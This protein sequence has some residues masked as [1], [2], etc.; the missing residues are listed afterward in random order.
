MTTH[1]NL[2]KAIQTYGDRF[3]IEPMHKD[4]KSNA[5]DIEGTRVTK[6]KRIE[7]ILIPISLCYIMCVLEGDRKETA[8][9][10]IRAHKEKRTTGLFLVGLSAFTRILRSTAFDRIQRIVFSV[11]SI[12]FSWVGRGP[13]NLR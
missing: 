8:G 9:E 5:F 6:A 12:S 10:T 11:F 2:P 3:G 7:T 4:W 13:I 1:A